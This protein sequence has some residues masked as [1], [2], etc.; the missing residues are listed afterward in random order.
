MFDAKNYGLNVAREYGAYYLVKCPFHD[1]DN[2]SAVFWKESGDFE[3]YGCRTK[4]KISD[5][6][7]DFVSVAAP[8]LVGLGKDDD[9][10]DIICSSVIGSPIAIEYCRKRGLTP[11]SII[12]YNIK[13]EFI[14]NNLVFEQFDSNG[15]AGY[16]RRRIDNGLQRYFV[17]GKKCDIWPRQQFLNIIN[18]NETI[19]ISEGPFKAMRLNQVIGFEIRSFSI[20]GSQLRHSTVEILSQFKGQIVLIG[21]NDVAGKKLVN[22]FHATFPMARIF[23]PKIP[24][25][26]ATDIQCQKMYESILRKLNDESFL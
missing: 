17:I 9:F 20:F 5:F 7:A 22:E 24:F 12:S 10:E 11:N 26:D 6:D 23:T 2:P 16:I 19:F 15:K 8:Y 14:K 3:C 4:K 13:W 21:D 18:T 25:D 1:D